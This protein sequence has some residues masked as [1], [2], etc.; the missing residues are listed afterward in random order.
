MRPNGHIILA[1]PAPPRPE[2]ASS[3]RWEPSLEVSSSAASHGHR[4]MHLFWTMKMGGHSGAEDSHR[5]RGQQTPSPGDRTRT[6]ECT[7]YLTQ[8]TPRACK[9]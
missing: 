7:L 2:T 9:Q 1:A 5:G 4:Q 3:G 6:K 8:G